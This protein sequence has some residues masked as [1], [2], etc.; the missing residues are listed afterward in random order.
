[1]SVIGPTPPG[2]GETASAIGSTDGG[3]DVADQAHRPVVLVDGV[4]PDVDDDR[5]LADEV[6]ADQPGHADGDDED[7]GRQRVLGQAPGVKR[8]PVRRDDGGVA[9][10]PE[11]RRRL[12][13]VV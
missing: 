5:A 12:A 13:D 8:V 2:T 1:M 3:V 11:D 6:A 10:Q 9:L 4:D 7:V